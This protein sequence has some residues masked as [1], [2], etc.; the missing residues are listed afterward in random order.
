MAELTLKGVSKIY[1]K[2]NREVQAV[3]AFNL[4]CRDG[5]FVALL[6]PS[7]CGK[8]TTLRMIAG[9][10][11]IT[12]GEIRIGG[13]KVNDLPPKKRGIG[14]A[15]ENY[16]LYPPLSV[17]DNIAFNLRAQGKSEE[18][19]RREVD[20]IAALLHIG[21][22]LEKK[23]AALSGGE[24]QRVNIA[25]AIIRRP[26][27]L[28]LDEPLSHLD[29]RMRQ[30]MRT[31]LKRLH[32]E[33]RCTTVIVTHDQSE[34]MALADRIAVM[35]EGE[36]QQFGTPFEIY[37]HP[38]NEF[39]AGFI[40]D[41][42]MNLFAVQVV[43]E[44]ETP[45]FKIEG[46]GKSFA[47][48]DRLRSVVK[49]GMRYRFGVRPTDVRVVA[50]EDGGA[51]ATRVTVFENLGEEHRIHIR[52]DKNQMISVVTDTD[53]RF[54]PGDSIFLRFDEEKIHL[55]DPATGR[56]IQGQEAIPA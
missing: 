40:G 44:E 41:P 38:V 11:E 10:E 3:K 56:R 30:R 25:R 5:E 54:Q 21:D 47:V 34:A 51:L 35:N 6:G 15:F 39:V 55:F 26:A 36:L 46:C 53:V 28:L 12:S 42:P 22:L 24:K 52:L 1:R 8:S 45:V 4:S 49:E 50:P 19:I 2:R 37:R 31:E 33:I 23:P 27:V 17:Y 29:G 48:P 16:A 9:L 14:L 43:K 20:R 7:G 13:K 18:E 32:N